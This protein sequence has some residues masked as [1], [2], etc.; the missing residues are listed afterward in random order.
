MINKRSG[1]V[2]MFDYVWNRKHKVARITNIVTGKT[3]SINMT[4]L[5]YLGYFEDHF[6]G[7]DND[8]L[9]VDILTAFCLAK[10]NHEIVPKGTIKLRK[11]DDGEIFEFR[12]KKL[13]VINGKDSRIERFAGQKNIE[14]KAV[15]NN[16]IYKIDFH[17]N[18]IVRFPNFYTISKHVCMGNAVPLIINLI[19]AITYEVNDYSRGIKK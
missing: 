2:L 18:T 1:D 7:Y 17:K 6:P 12:K 5:V 19:K 10:Y 3:A 8:S 15:H 9:F 4:N 14:C 11:L 16:N 13:T